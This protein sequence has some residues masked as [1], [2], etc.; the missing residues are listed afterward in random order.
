MSVWSCTTTTRHR[1]DSKEPNLVPLEAVFCYIKVI[2]CKYTKPMKTLTC[3]LCD[4]EVSA[5]TFE[6]WMNE[7]KPHYLEKHADVMQSH[8]GG[9]PE[10]MKAKMQ[11]WMK[12]NRTRFETA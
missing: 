3:D 12:E 7:L 1:T 2:E 10:E 11:N 9:S 4:H 8:S 5:E 6:E